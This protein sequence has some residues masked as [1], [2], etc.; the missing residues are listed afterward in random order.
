MAAANDGDIVQVRGGTYAEH[1]TVNRAVTLESVTG[2]TV[3]VD[4]SDSLLPTINV[5]AGATIKNL[6]IKGS[7]ALGAGTHFQECNILVNAPGQTVTITGCALTDWNHCGIKAGSRL[8]ASGNTIEAGGYTIL[9]HCIYLASQNAM[10][11]SITNNVLQGATGY[12]LHLYPYEYNVTATGNTISNNGGGGI[13][14][15]GDGHTI[16]GNTISNNGATYQNG[17]IQ[18]FHYGMNNLTLTN[19]VASGNVN[20]DYQASFSAGEE[21]TNLVFT[22]NTGVKNF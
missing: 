16:S 9:D 3:I 20:Y 22:N 8:M 10:G 6:S 11:H 13:C 4:G 14:V 7:Y 18:F 5:I 15:T 17:G 12:G 1:L 21:F 19:N 2:Q